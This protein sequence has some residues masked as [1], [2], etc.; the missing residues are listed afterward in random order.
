MRDNLNILS[1]E[2]LLNLGLLHEVIKIHSERLNLK[3]DHSKRHRHQ[4][5]RNTLPPSP[6]PSHHSRHFR[7]QFWETPF[8]ILVVLL[9]IPFCPESVHN[10]HH[11]PLARGGF[12]IPRRGIWWAW[13][14]GARCWSSLPACWMAVFSAVHHMFDHTSWQKVPKLL[15]MHSDEINVFEAREEY[16]EG[17]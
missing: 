3:M 13:W 1:N 17:N 14:K 11:S 4:S 6:T 10:V 2:L 5:P 16:F 8:M 9:W 12:R 7:E 15:Q